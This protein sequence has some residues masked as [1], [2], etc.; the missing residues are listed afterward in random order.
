MIHQTKILHAGHTFITRFRREQI[1][2]VRVRLAIQADRGWFTFDKAF[3]AN[4][5]LL[6]IETQQMDEIEK[7]KDR[8]TRQGFN[9]QLTTHYE[10][11]QVTMWHS[12]PG[13]HRPP[14]GRGATLRDA[15]TAAEEDL[16][17]MLSKKKAVA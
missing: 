1:P 2:D 8:W 17:E 11:W 9:L 4:Q 15:L 10:G 12:L 16:M 6:Q 7:V 14:F 5:E 3:Q 13:L